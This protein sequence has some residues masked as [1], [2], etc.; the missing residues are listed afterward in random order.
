MRKGAY[1]KMLD[2]LAGLSVPEPAKRQFE[3]LIRRSAALDGIASIDRLERVKFARR[4][5]DQKES[6][7]TICRRLQ[8]RYAIGRSQAYLI[9]AEA[10]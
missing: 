5:L 1:Q 6:R 4:L 8:E 10:L 2:G 7:T 9:I 3:E